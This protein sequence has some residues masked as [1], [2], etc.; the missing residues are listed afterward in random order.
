[1]FASAQSI[2]EG[3]WDSWGGVTVEGALVLC[4]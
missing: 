2:R 4:A 3:L 1:M